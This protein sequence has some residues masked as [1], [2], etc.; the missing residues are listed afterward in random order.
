MVYVAGGSPFEASNVFSII[1][2]VQEE[3]D[4]GDGIV[5]E[6][7]SHHTA[8]CAPSVHGLVSPS[9]KLTSYPIPKESLD[10]VVVL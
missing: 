8:L 3:E 2:P 5:K 4:P 7:E 1:H 9:L 10:M 6:K